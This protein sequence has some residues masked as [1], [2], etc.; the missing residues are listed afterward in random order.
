MRDKRKIRAARYAEENHAAL[1]RIMSVDLAELE[2]RVLAAA[3]NHGDPR[4]EAASVIFGVPVEHVT[5]AQRKVGRVA[6]F[7]IIYGWR[8]GK[9][10]P[11]ALAEL[12]SVT[13][14]RPGMP[15]MQNIN[16]RVQLAA[17]DQEKASFLEGL[18]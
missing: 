2:R 13:G 5:E 15:E 18:E 9:R 12:L 3:G 11:E 10:G 4:A 8:A 17:F 14:R 1:E 6:G 16:M 7:G